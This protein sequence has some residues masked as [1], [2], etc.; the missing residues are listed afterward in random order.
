MN[1]KSKLHDYIPG[2]AHT[3]SRGED[4]V[5]A[6]I[7]NVLKKGK[8][9]YVWDMDDNKYLDYGMALRANILGYANDDVDNAGIEE[10]KKGNNLTKPSEV[11]YLAAKKLVELIPWVDQVK[12]AKNGSNVTTAAVKLA[13]AYTK[14]QYVIICSD[15]PF[16]SFDDW[17]IGT[18]PVKRGTLF[19]KK[20]P[21][22]KNSNDLKFK[23]NDLESLENQFKKFPDDIAAVIMEPC[24]TE[25]PKIYEDNQ[26][27]LHKAHN[28]CKKYGSVFIMDEMITGFR[29]G[30]TGACGVY[31]VKPDLVTYGKAIANGFSL[32][33]LGG[34]KEIM[35][36]GDVITEGR[37]RVFLLSS[38]HGAEMSSL[39]AMIKNIDILIENNV[40]EYIRNYG[41][42]LIN[43][44]NQIAKKLEVDKYFYFYGL[45][46]NPY[47]ATNN[48]NGDSCLKFRTLFVQ[49]MAKRKVIMAFVAISYS[50]KEEQ[51]NITLKAIEESLLVYK[52]ALE[53]G[54]DEYLE[55]YIIKP[56]FRKYN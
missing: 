35:S 29:F 3:Y 25:E 56:V 55:S 8:D 32:A 22:L 34:K 13:R 23:Y 26:N 38:T 14:K 6:N 7:P 48:K 39:G 18:T 20:C 37:E 11:E 28:L 17:F 46:Q 45:P 43:S 2:G 21:F 51:L 52:K 10:I 12:F 9:C 42:R 54:I 19:D 49:E 16:F 27:F 33:V 47:F 41:E 36:L 44:A 15:H 5:P 4:T 1:Y 30:I 50:H 40:S 31:N 24:T 53:N